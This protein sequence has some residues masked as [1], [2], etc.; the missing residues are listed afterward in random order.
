MLTINFWLLYM[1]CFLFAHKQD[2]EL[3]KEEILK[4]CSS[5]ILG[6]NSIIRS[7]GQKLMRMKQLNDICYTLPAIINT[8]KI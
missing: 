1:S 8:Y 6:E 3:T 7:C 2:F 4:A 5:F